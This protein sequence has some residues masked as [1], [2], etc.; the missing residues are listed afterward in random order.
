MRR[1]LNCSDQ[2]QNPNWHN[3]IFILSNILPS[4]LSPRSFFFFFFFVFAQRPPPVSEIPSRC[5]LLPFPAALETMLCDWNWYARHG[6][7]NPHNL[8]SHLRHTQSIYFIIA[9]LWESDLRL[10]RFSWISW[11]QV[12]RQDMG[13]QGRGGALLETWDE[14]KWLYIF[15]CVIRL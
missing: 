10:P 13:G 15:E 6:E 11:S 7:L 3:V 2:A 4:I 12:G 9:V 14:T 1:G 5:P 8:L